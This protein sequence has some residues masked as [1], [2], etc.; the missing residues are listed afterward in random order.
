[1]LARCYSPKT[2]KVRE[3]YIGCTVSENFKYYPYFYEWCN[4]QVGFSENNFDLDKDLL[5][6]VSKYYSEGTCVFLPRE[7]NV[8]LI[9][10]NRKRG[11]F[12]SGV[13]YNKNNRNFVVKLSV[14]NEKRHIGVFNSVTD[15]V[16]AYKAAKEGYLKEL[17]EKWKDAI[18]HRAYDALMNYE[19]DIDD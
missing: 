5:S 1:M 9:K 3:T 7:I 11:D 13:T 17:A 2:H 14:S 6:G 12:P 4:R 10:N 15:A 19:V 18:D 16:K 8:A